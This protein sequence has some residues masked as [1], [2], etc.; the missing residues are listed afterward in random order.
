MSQEEGSKFHALRESNARTITHGKFVT[1]Q[2]N[3]LKVNPK[4]I[5]KDGSLL[6]V[7]TKVN[8]KKKHAMVDSGASYNFI[9]KEEASRL[10]IT[11]KKEKGWLKIMISEA[12][13]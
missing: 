4:P 6:F 13:T 1:S 8:G 7:E 2:L 10:K 9:K 5:I 12:K 11:L 3:S